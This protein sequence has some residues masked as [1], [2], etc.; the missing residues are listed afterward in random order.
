MC[1]I[2]VNDI[3]DDLKDENRRLFEDLQFERSLNKILEQIKTLSI[4]LKDNCICTENIEVFRQ[5]NDLEIDYK[6]IKAKRNDDQRNRFQ[7]PTL[8]EKLR[9]VLNRPMSPG[10]YS[11]LI[12]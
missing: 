1:D 3:F 4:V 11:R 10:F 8:Y 7:R 12:R 2:I 9:P 6:L 5:L